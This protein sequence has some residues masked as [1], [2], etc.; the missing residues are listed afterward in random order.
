MERVHSPIRLNPDADVSRVIVMR[1][2]GISER[3]EMGS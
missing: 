2:R 1:V 3:I